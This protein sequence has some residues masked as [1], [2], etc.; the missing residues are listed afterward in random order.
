[1]KTLENS[2][3]YSKQ[4]KSVKQVSNIVSNKHSYLMLFLIIFIVASSLSFGKER[5]DDR[6]GDSGLESDWGYRF[7][8]TVG[9]GAL[10]Y[11]GDTDR[12]INASKIVVNTDIKKRTSTPYVS[13][14]MGLDYYGEKATVT[15]FFNIG[16]RL[17]Y[18]GV[19]QGDGLF[20]QIT[21]EVVPQWGIGI[22]GSFPLD[23]ASATVLADGNDGYSLVLGLE[24]HTG[25]FMVGKIPESGAGCEYNETA[26]QVYC[27]STSDS[28]YDRNSDYYEDGSSDRVVSYSG[29]GYRLDAGISKG[30]YVLKAFYVRDVF[31]LDEPHTYSRAQNLYI[32]R[33]FPNDLSTS[34]VGIG[35]GYEPHHP[36]LTH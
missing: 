29:S 20:S 36:F 1:M 14:M 18:G 15:P 4:D 6:N 16:Y 23:T 32:K 11:G 10:S 9:G 24:L 34:I 7:G 27:N 8:V 22:Q 17:A 2:K 28:K 35:I 33:M 26:K 5:W 3:K 25:Y 21:G 12:F 31:L 30:D 19:R 13:F